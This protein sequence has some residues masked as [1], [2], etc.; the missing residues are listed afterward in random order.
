MSSPESLWLYHHQNQIKDAAK[1]VS[2]IEK[3]VSLPIPKDLEEMRATQDD[4]AVTHAEMLI[5]KLKALEDVA[6][7]RK[8]SKAAGAVTA[9]APGTT[10]KEKKQAAAV[11]KQQSKDIAEAQRIAEDEGDF[12][13]LR[14]TPEQ[15]KKDR[16]SLVRVDSVLDALNF[17]EDEMIV[18]K[19]GS[20]AAA[21]LAPWKRTLNTL[22]WVGHNWRV[23]MEA[24]KLATSEPGIWGFVLAVVV[25]ASASSS[26]DAL[27]FAKGLG[28]SLHIRDLTA[29]RIRNSALKQ[30]TQTRHRRI[31]RTRD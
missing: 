17:W 11:R 30:G 24:V 31:K 25:L 26:T 14:Y 29:E 12:R 23:I 4:F 16:Q 15:R 28:S 27:T 18:A 20:P 7:T 2:L 1:R 8:I 6:K 10:R 21:F 13:H 5:E 9:P 22:S 19:V 3:W